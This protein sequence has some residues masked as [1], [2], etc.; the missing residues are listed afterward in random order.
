MTP[1]YCAAFTNSCTGY[2]INL[3]GYLWGQWQKN[4]RLIFIMGW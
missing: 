2:S 4:K 1:E 3:K